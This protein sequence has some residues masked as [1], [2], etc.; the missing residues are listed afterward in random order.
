VS[1]YPFVLQEISVLIE[2]K[3]VCGKQPHNHAELG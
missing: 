3:K 1:F 2:L